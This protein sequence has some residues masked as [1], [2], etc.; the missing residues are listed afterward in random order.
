MSRLAGGLFDAVRRPALTLAQNGH[1]VT[2]LS[3]EDPS[4]TQDLA[5]WAPCEPLVAHRKGPAAIGYAPE[6]G[7]A[8]HKGQFDIVHQHGIWQAFSAQVSA[9]RRRTGGPV[10]ISPHGML[11]PWAVGNSAWKKRLAGALYERGNLAHA[12]CLHALNASEAQAMRGFGLT[13]PIAII[14]NGA[15]LPED[16]ETPPPDW[17]PGGKVLLFIGRIHPKKG[18]QELIEA[19]AL[20]SAVNDW[21]L[22]IA[23]WDD[24]GHVDSLREAV[25]RH[26]LEGRVTLPGPL[27]GAD[28]DAALRHASAFI[29]PSY[30]EGLPMTVLEAWSYSLPVLMTRECN[31]PEGFVQGAA[32]EITPD[33]PALAASLVQALAGHQDAALR[34]MG[35]K[36][37]ALVEARFSWQQIAS[38][39]AQVYRWMAGQVTDAP[40]CV[41]MPHMKGNKT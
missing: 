15:D 29:L 5:D 4:S 40:T 16:R 20:A 28:K 6:I 41:Q 26:G 38:E 12:R 1:K 34:D 33:P 11:D 18:V 32:V 3:L 10:T 35:Q 23:G 36:G 24:G 27:F 30:S 17:W 25:A 22:V 19:F 39:H 8:L 21:N 2:V 9:W 7:R 14:P 37:R 13:N 31:L